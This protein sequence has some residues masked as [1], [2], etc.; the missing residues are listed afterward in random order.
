MTLRQKKKRKK[1]A[2]RSDKWRIAYLL[3]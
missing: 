1:T 2:R 3:Y